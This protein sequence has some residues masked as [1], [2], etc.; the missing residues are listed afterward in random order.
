MEI[1]PDKVFRRL[2]YVKPDFKVCCGKPTEKF[3]FQGVARLHRLCEDNTTVCI[4]PLEGYTGVACPYCSH[5]NPLINKKIK[6]EVYVKDDGTYVLY[7]MGTANGT[8]TVNKR[9]IA[10]LSFAAPN[11]KHPLHLSTLKGLDYYPSHLLP[12]I[13]NMYEKWLIYTNKLMGEIL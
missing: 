3:F 11:Y 10:L 9:L 12:M 6:Y 13:G 4:A 5:V 8:V 7:K 1:S 2:V